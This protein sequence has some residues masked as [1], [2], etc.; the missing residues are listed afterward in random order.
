MWATVPA[1]IL[2]GL[3][4]ITVTRLGDL[5]QIPTDPDMLHISVTGQQFSW[6][7]VYG[8]TGRQDNQRSASA[9]RSAKSSST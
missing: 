4:G 9:R 6:T 2:I 7:F 5:N 8:D 3:F 1:L